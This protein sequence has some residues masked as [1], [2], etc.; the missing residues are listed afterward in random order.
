MYFVLLLFANIGETYKYVVKFIIKLYTFWINNQ[1][2]KRRKRG[3]RK[4]KNSMVLILFNVNAVSEWMEMMTKA[5]FFFFYSIFAVGCRCRCCCR[6]WW[7]WWQLWFDYNNPTH[8]YIQFVHCVVIVIKWKSN[9]M[10]FGKKVCFF[11]WWEKRK[12]ER[13]FQ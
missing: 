4:K 10:I 8:R 3:K 12:E 11:F 7:W 9:K 13:S 5:F 2:K 1:K 6:R